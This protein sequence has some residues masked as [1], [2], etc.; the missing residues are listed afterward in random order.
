[1]G[2]AADPFQFGLNL[3]IA[4]G[5]ACQDRDGCA[6]LGKPN[7]YRPPDPPVAACDER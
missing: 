3:G 5:V 7:G 1:V 6:C 4:I 2:A